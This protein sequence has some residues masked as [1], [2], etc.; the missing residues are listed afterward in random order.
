MSETLSHDEVARLVSLRGDRLYSSRER[1]IRTDAALR[2]ERD[3]L[4]G[5]ILAVRDAEYGDHGAAWAEAMQAIRDEG[6]AIVV[7]G[8]EP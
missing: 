4:A 8:R 2:A 6:D 3:R 5:L 1:L 7:R